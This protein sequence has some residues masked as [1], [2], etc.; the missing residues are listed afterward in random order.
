[1]VFREVHL[2]KVILLLF[3]NK[4]NVLSGWLVSDNAAALRGH[5]SNLPPGSWVASHG[6]EISDLHNR[7]SVHGVSN[8]YS[9]WPRSHWHYSK[10]LKDR[11][12]V[13]LCTQYYS[14]YTKCHTKQ[15]LWTNID[16]LYGDTVTHAMTMTEKSSQF[17]G[18]LKKVN[19]TIQNPLANIFITDSKVYMAVKVYLE[20]E[21]AALRLNTVVRENQFKINNGR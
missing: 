13:G 18:S 5:R 7:L 21:I 20:K 10:I 16:N 19:G 3:P 9:Y 15:N 12:G 14:L 4:A 6:T 8:H 1:M 17:H 11:I 2:V